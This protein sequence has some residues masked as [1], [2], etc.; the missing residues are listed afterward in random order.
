[1]ADRLGPQVGHDRP[2]V[3]AAG[4][5]TEVP[6]VGPPHRADERRLGQVGDVAHGADPEALESGEDIDYTGAS[7]PIDMDV[8][9]AP[10]TGV[11]DIFQYDE[12][13]LAVA[14]EVSVEKP[15]PAAAP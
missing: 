4:E 6:A 9:G 13:R 7:G 5:L 2:G 12:D 15:N 11:Y 10:T 1:M 3:D 8:R 14:G